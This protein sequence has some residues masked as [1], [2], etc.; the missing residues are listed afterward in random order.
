MTKYPVEEHDEANSNE[1]QEYKILEK[2]LNNQP[3]D[4]EEHAEETQNMTTDPNL[5]PSNTLNKLSKD[6][7]ERDAKK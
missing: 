7:E 2:I 3:L 1:S 5:K 6:E 4:I